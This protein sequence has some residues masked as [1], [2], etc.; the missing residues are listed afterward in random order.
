[1]VKK[2][3]GLKNEET[4]KPENYRAIAIQNAIYK[5][6]TAIIAEVIMDY[7]ESNNIVTEEHAAGK[8]TVGDVPM[9][10][11]FG[12]FIYGHTVFLTLKNGT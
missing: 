3:T 5:T 6:Y 12:D 1:M 2:R 10:V 11:L 7:C 8:E 4:H 9:Q